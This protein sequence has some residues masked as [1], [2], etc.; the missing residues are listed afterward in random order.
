MLATHGLSCPTSDAVP[1]PA[2][3]GIF[4]S[5]SPPAAPAAEQ[6]PLAGWS[7]VAPAACT[8]L[9]AQTEGWVLGGFIA[10]L[11]HFRTKPIPPDPLSHRPQLLAASA[12][13]GFPAV[14]PLAGVDSYFYKIAFL[15]FL[16]DLNPFP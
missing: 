5:V 11:H 9:A 13:R 6:L 7:R 2:A 15:C 8:G 16:I 14:L 1:A 12:W 10:I 4:H 3:A